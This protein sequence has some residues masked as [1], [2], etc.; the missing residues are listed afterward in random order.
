MTDRLPRSNSQSHLPNYGQG[1]S[2]ENNKDVD[3]KKDGASARLDKNTGR[4]DSDKNKAAPQMKSKEEKKI[5]APIESD[6]DDGVE[7]PDTFGKLFL[8][9]G[10]SAVARRYADS[11]ESS[12]EDGAGQSERKTLKSPRQQQSANKEKT[13]NKKVPKL[14]LKNLGN[15]LGSLASDRRE[16]SISPRKTNRETHKNTQDSIYSTRNTG[17]CK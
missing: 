14:S 6:S 2:D 1:Q 8:G 16:M 9:Q 15:V 10:A 7:V 17:A 3:K 13:T 4:G 5:K 11:D 12:S